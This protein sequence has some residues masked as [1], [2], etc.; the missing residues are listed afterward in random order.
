MTETERKQI[1]L[2]IDL[3]RGLLPDLPRLARD[4]LDKARQR[5]IALKESDRRAE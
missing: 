2:H 4:E 3:A 5:L 1:M